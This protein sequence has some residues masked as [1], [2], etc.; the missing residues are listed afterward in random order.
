M[1]I[2]ETDICVIGGGSGGLS[3]AAG[4]SQM[5]A[6]VVLLEGHKMGGDCL[7]FG[8]VPSKAL[9]AAGKAANAI[10]H[11]SRFGI[12]SGDINVDMQKIRDHVQ[13]VIAGIA[14][15]D[16]PERFEA[17]GVQVIQEMGEFISPKEVKAGKN[18]IRAKYFVISTGSSAMVP[19]IPGLADAAY[20]TNENIFEIT[21]TIK[22]LIVL[23][24]G[25]IGIELAQA[26][27]RLGADVTVLE[28]FSILGKDDAEAVDVVRQRLLEEGLTLHE[29]TKVIG[30]AKNAGG[31]TITLEKNG[32]TI[33]ID[34]THFLVAGGRKPNLDKLGLDKANVDFAPQGIKV[35]AR[36]RTS[37]K[38]IFAIGD[39][40]GGLQ[41]TH[42][43][44][45]DAGIVIRNM[46]FKL[47]AKA[48]YRAA[49]WVTYT[50]P[51]LAHVGLNEDMAEKELGKG[52]FQILRWPFAE[53]DRASAERE[54]DGFAKVIV[55]KRGRVLGATI[56]GL[57]AGELIAPWVMAISGK[58]KI[59]TLAG[60]ILPY[61]TFGEISKRAASSYYTP[62]IF[63]E[64]MRKIVRFLMKF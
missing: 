5:G 2:V 23:G 21:D 15:H 35:D 41:F 7:N 44:G 59:G 29:G 34:G 63:S 18:T 11:A 9:I 28:M 22:H 64:K 39:A 20:Y 12:T 42:T 47:P 32:E 33:K 46:L 17:L 27:R 31:V 45:Y 49:P 26:H 14:P 19:P 24:G 60:I 4:A 58:Q 13:G 56:V 62:K 25:P 36:L 3:V 50:D 8:C 57:H 1:S 16:S 48:D 52:N 6:R 30:V 43:A 38:K 54:T 51:E 37:N 61:P 55:D 53:N 10:K 40:R